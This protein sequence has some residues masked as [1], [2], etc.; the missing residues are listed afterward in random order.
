MWIWGET[1]AIIVKFSTLHEVGWVSAKNVNKLTQSENVS[2]AK[3]CIGHWWKW[4]LKRLLRPH[5]TLTPSVVNNV[6]AVNEQFSS[7]QISQEGIY[8]AG[9]TTRK[10]ESLKYVLL[11][12]MT[13]RKGACRNEV[14]FGK[15]S[16]K[17]RLCDFSILDWSKLL[18]RR[19]IGGQKSQ[20]F[21][22][23]HL[24]M[25]PN[26]KLLKGLESTLAVSNEDT[27]M[28]STSASTKI[29]SLVAR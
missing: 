21:S 7:R 4:K 10:H 9:P 14:C 5:G 22:R 23:R 17:G 6:G 29:R 11:A 8:K 20:N 2:L 16:T 13:Q 24:W 18:T 26:A 12:E 1:I 3:P 27:Q 25:A 19:G 15:G 28:T